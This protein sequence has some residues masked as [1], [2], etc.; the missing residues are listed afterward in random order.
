[1]TKLKK[2]AV[3]VLAVL[4]AAC[5]TSSAIAYAFKGSDTDLA[6]AN[7]ISR[8]GGSVKSDADKFFNSEVIYKLPETVAD[9]DDISVI[10]TMNNQ[11]I[12]DAYF[13]SDGTGKVSDFANSAEARAIANN[14][15]V[16][17]DKLIN[18]L[19]K[20][21]INFTVGEEYDTIL[22]G[23][24]ITLKAK[25][26][27][28]VDGLLSDDAVLIVGD[29]YEKAATEIVTN[30]V[31]VY[32]T[33][34]F[35]SS[36]SEY[37]GDG[38]VVA[39][40]DTGLDYT[41]SA[42][43]VDNFTTKQEAFTLQNVS[44]K[45]GNTAANN[46]TS[47]LT[48]EDVYVSKKVPYA[49]DYADK[50]VDVAPINSE[51]GTH[52]AG[53]IAGKDDKITGVAPNAQL[54]IMK[55]FSDLQD[56]AKT[57][58]ILAA[59]EDCVVL[60]VDVINMSL[61]T[62]C[63][64]TRE[65][66]KKNVNRIY[67]SIRK[68]GISL[69]TAASN[70]YNAT[71]GSDK[72]GSNGL[73][74]NPDSG[75]VGSPSTYEG[76]LSVASVDGVKTPYL[77]YNN[78]IIY[79]TEASTSSAK[80]KSFVDDILS[81]VGGVDSY[82][83]QYVTIPG[84][85]R[86]SDYLEVNEFYKDKIVLV[87]RG[88]TTFEDKVRIAL[89]VKGA[90][91][92][93]IYNNVSGTISMSVGKDIGAVCSISQDEGEK[94]AAAGSG[95]LKISKNQTAGPFMSDFSSWGPT[96]DLKIK[97]E[98]TAHG[99]EILS[100][101]PGQDYDRLSGT[102]M[103]APNLAG[104][105]TL[106]RQY[107]KYSG[108]FGSDLDPVT[109][110]N[111]VNQ[112]M[113]STADIVYNK[114][115]LPYAVRKQGAGLIN[116]AKS[117]STASYISTFDAEGKEMGKSK[118]ELGDDK[119][120][121]GVYEMTFAIN[122][123]S[124][125]S[126]SY[127]IDSVIQT[128]GVSPTYTSHG[129]TT[130]TMEG[131]LLNPTT[132]VTAVNGKSA[133]N[134]TVTVPAGDN[135]SVTVKIVLS[136][137][138]KKFMDES[139][140]YGMYV[141]GFITLK[142]TQG[143]S[144]D[145]SVPML[146]FYGDWTEA[147]IFDE[148]YYDTNI[149]ELDKGLDAEDK[150]M[151]DAYATR[152]IG[153]LYSDY[154][155]TLGSYYFVQ[156][157][158]STPIAA[159]KEHIAISNLQDEEHSSINSIR[160]ITAGLLR[161]A[162]KV[163]IS[164]V[165]DST[166]NCIFN[167]TEW[168]KL[169]S[170]SRGNTIYGSS[171]DVEFGA[172]EH[173]LKNN[174]KYTVTVEAYIDYGTYDEKSEK[175][176]DQ[177]N[178]RNTFTF[179]L[180]IDFEAPIVTDVEYRSEYDRS[181]RQTHLYADLSIYDNHY[182]MGVSFGQIAE[183]EPGSEYRFTM[184]SF[185]RYITPVYSSFNSTAKVTV[186]LTDY[187]NQI[188]QS[189]G[190]SY[191]AD[192]SVNVVK[193]NSFIAQVYD[194]AMNYATYEIRLPDE[195]ASMFF[196]QEEIQLSPNETFVITDILN[197][198]PTN[199]WKQVLDVTISD[200]DKEIIGLANQTIIAKTSG[201]A[202]ITVIGYD[203]DGNK[204]FEQLRVK[205]LDEGDEGYNGNLSI[206][207]VNKFTLTGYTTEKAYYATT[208][209]EREI[210]LTGGTYDFGGSYSLSMF[211]SES[212]TLKYILDSYFPEKT[213]VS[214]KS[215]NTRIASVDDNGTITALAEGNTIITVNVA[216]DGKNTLYSGRVSIKVKD[217]FTTNSIY[218]MSYKG[219]GDEVIIPDDRGIT[220]IQSYAFSNYEFVPKVPE[221]GDVIDEEDPYFIKQAPIGEDTITRIVIPE[222]VETIEAYAF[223]KLTALKEVV[224]PS[225]LKKIGVGAFKDCENLTN[226]NLENVQFINEKAFYGCKITRVALDKVVAIGN[227]A[228]ANCKLNYL[229]LPVSAQSLGIGAFSANETLTSIDFKAS[230]MK[231]GSYA[232]ANCSRLIEASINAT[233]LSS[234]AF[235]GCL[236]LEKVTLGR[237]VSVIGELA[238][239]D[240]KVS[241]FNIDSRNKELTTEEN[242]A[243][244]FRGEELVL[245]AP[246]YSKTTL[247]VDVTEIASGAFAGNTN[248]VYV[249]AQNAKIIGDYAFAHCTFL[250]RIYADNVEYIGDYAFYNCQKLTATPDLGKIEYIGECAFSGPIDNL[251][252]TNKKSATSITFVDVP[253]NAEIGAYAFAFNT[254]LTS[255]KL[256][257][258][259]TVG[260]GAFYTPINF[261]AVYENCADMVT[262]NIP[263]SSVAAAVASHF[264]T[265]YTQFI[266][267][268]SGSGETYNYYRYNY[269]LMA[270][271][272]L[273]SV[274]VGEDT[275]IGD[276]AFGDN[277][278]LT[279]L[280][281]GENVAIGNRAFFNCY[282]LNSVDLSKIK[283][284]GDYAFSGTETANFQKTADGF[285]LAYEYSY[286]SGEREIIDIS[287]S[288]AA[289]G[290]V[291]V[292]LSAAEKL[293]TGTFANN[294]ILESVEL[295]AEMIEVPA[296][297]FAKTSVMQITLPEK[298]SAIGNYAFYGA[299]LTQVDLSKVSFIGS[300]A[301]ADNDLI[302][303]VLNADGIVI[304]DALV[305]TCIG[306]AAFAYNRSL[307]SVDNLDKAESIGDYAFIGTALPSVN[308]KSAKYVGDFAFA[309]SGITNI[310]FGEKLTYVGENPFYGCAIES[311]GKVEEV[312]FGESVIS[313]SLNENYSVSETVK[314]ING[315]LYSV[316]PNGLVLVSYPALNTQ[317]EFVVE[318][319]TVRIS[320]RAFCN[321]SLVTV[322]LPSALKSI[323]DK[324]FYECNKL[325]TVVFK[326]YEAPTLEEEY[327]SNYAN[328]ENLPFAGYMVISDSNGGVETFEGLGIS[329]YYMWNISTSPNNF[330]Y[331]A[332]FVDYIGHVDNKLI[333]VKPANGQSY[334]TF[335]LTQYF[336]TIVQGANA[337]TEATLAVIDM[338]N[339][340][341]QP[342]TLQHKQ[343][344]A[345]AR[346]AYNALPSTE[347]QA[348]VDNYSRLVEAERILVYLEPVTGTPT[349]N[350][351]H[352]I[353]FWQ[354]HFYIGYIIAGVAVIA[355]AAY[356]ALNILKKKEGAS[357]VA[358]DSETESSGESTAMD[359]DNETENSE[360]KND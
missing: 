33:G 143:T 262:A 151:A 24:E 120:R 68:A 38:V 177:K 22:S 3:S 25:D 216:F 55:V 141:E 236:R 185:G 101:V 344:V 290:L 56:G 340:L 136:D 331:G 201:T 345:D 7:T 203:K 165:E 310:T 93:I 58:W 145:M 309:Q 253:D 132:T 241:A 351:E 355:L 328:Y 332:N 182:S 295:G 154:I 139:F 354:K 90:A 130:V 41:H 179:P 192:G 254:Q 343:M 116:I 53:I 325:K 102:S 226:I 85:G 83:F 181:S 286:D 175:Y 213:G 338:I 166:G 187:I 137:A 195:V 264:N 152:V 289:P 63:G 28:R 59:L 45:V 228:F 67:D 172:L 245:V 171:I 34:I 27:D 60:G 240:T 265:Y 100:A 124:T 9:N 52:V 70:D 218:L 119:N 40:L 153:G 69:I 110:T 278:R 329:K 144:V 327:V 346:A 359:A 317:S 189:A 246:A 280:I 292:N 237:D 288:S 259:V 248:L 15:S 105:A 267:S 113:M 109:V 42:F 46:F 299:K 190:I 73:T 94:L 335:I 234:Y 183:N 1:M 208:N 37:Q 89:N 337:A 148:E 162:K 314:V 82:D 178:V 54:A 352:D 258:K 127:S 301:F 266:Y 339:A 86:E 138:D 170:F 31:D 316:V 200:K 12:M 222:G 71:F 255:V 323:G 157:P 347:Q 297:T 303:V 333:M 36:S 14:I 87:K 29:M 74:S 159:S 268:P 16:E 80:K 134:S 72:N 356:V 305:N 66:D 32:E 229:V 84:I 315:V 279:V 64:F 88:T 312:K 257:K 140:K 2:S 78:D 232:F 217:P 62:S 95:I 180:F 184:R 160:S 4:S 198:Y 294:A 155:A 261:A 8:V 249:Y 219:L 269:N 205:V 350:T 330:Y 275:V 117:T 271:S 210:G 282:S 6:Y 129:D 349:D 97:P 30:D 272:K 291:A 256:G 23:F 77:L 21:G 358:D 50:D 111:R 13:D 122:N 284:I 18:R 233:V 304:D 196:N 247:N 202:T 156:N 250:R 61:G 274:T 43:S 158:S 91:G 243:L 341:P 115:G 360:D 96:S 223:T 281:I 114:N 225:T 107:V 322:S 238:F 133:N 10:V 242:G 353:T 131:R 251:I 263:L 311:F 302:K 214:Y 348:L 57:S 20:A 26:F 199:S 313:H 215:G 98:I 108:T 283:T 163:D 11:S 206:P 306:G 320:A 244:I 324:A 293:G 230:K 204:V 221:E 307:V 186:E 19:Q 227:Y 239:V 79:F 106:I 147:P 296:Y 39:V 220:T 197:I 167:R 174:T 17:C 49:Y 76:S 326:S 334:D 126:V 103:A 112:L 235:A 277:S 276:N 150:L 44:E 318:E 298:V 270:T 135:V 308:L 47:N 194:Y 99:G 168:N 342:I 285:V 231:I 211:P 123:V 260:D 336:D 149:D 65:V 300:Y 92:I 142:A 35:D 224:L 5:I 191:G 207:E 161:N 173:N 146:A 193:N 273:E 169:K 81:T 125:S 321:S 75:T 51:H 209:E 121:T 319:G 164:I 212:V 118:L 357:P 48:G 128:E 176:L 287:T 104:A 252:N 188:K